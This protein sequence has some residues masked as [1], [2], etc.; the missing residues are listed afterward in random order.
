MVGA[1]TGNAGRGAAVG[2]IVGT[3]RGGRKQSQANEESKQQ[4]AQSAGHKH[5]SKAIKPRLLTA[6]KW[7]P[8]SED[9]R[10]AWM[11]A[12]IQSNRFA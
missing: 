9:S 3:V 11:H 7:L 8:S 12:V 5:N 1:I 2:A 4:A 10:P 6:T